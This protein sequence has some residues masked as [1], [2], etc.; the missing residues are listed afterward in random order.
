MSACRILHEVYARYGIA[1]SS[2]ADCGFIGGLEI[3]GWE[4]HSVIDGGD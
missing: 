1:D 2:I 3:G 4:F